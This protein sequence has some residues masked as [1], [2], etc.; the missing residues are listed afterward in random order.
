MGMLLLLMAACAGG[1]PDTG[2]D[3][4]SAPEVTWDGFGQGFFL[5]Y[6]GACHAAS[7]PDRHG[8]PEDQVFDTWA[9][10][11]AREE[12]IRRTVLI[13]GSMPMGGGVYP[14]DLTDLEVLLTCSD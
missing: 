4:A 9:Q 6:C 8:A 12:D 14:D 7:T 13:D 3:C 2:F 5:T 11:R 10:V 1:E